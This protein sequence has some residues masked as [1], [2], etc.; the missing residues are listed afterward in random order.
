VEIVVSGYAVR[1]SSVA[2]RRDTTVLRNV[3]YDMKRN[4]FHF[5]T[6]LL[7]ES[8]TLLTESKRGG[9]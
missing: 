1:A 2:R 4:M 6:Y 7:A 3:C 5:R 8:G 9:N